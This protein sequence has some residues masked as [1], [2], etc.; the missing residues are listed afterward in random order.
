M[1]VAAC[2]A[3]VLGL[4]LIQSPIETGDGLDAGGIVFN[5]LGAP[6]TRGS[7]LIDVEEEAFQD[8]LLELT[9]L[10]EAY[11]FSRDGVTLARGAEDGVDAQA[12]SGGFSIFDRKINIGVIGIENIP[13]SRLGT[14][15][16]VWAQLAD[17]GDPVWAGMLK[18]GEAGSRLALFDL[19]SNERFRGENNSVSFFVTEETERRPERPEGR[20]VLSGI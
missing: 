7:G 2:L 15:Y 8:R 6:E 11:W 9:G 5:D 3:V 17:G 13:D 18:P 1:P 19:S 20:I 10:A 4:A 12:F 16:N 14:Y